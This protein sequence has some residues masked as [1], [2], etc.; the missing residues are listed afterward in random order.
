MILYSIGLA[1]VLMPK[2]QKYLSILDIAHSNIAFLKFGIDTMSLLHALLH[3]NMLVVTSLN[4]NRLTITN[5]FQFS[6]FLIM[7][8][9]FYVIACMCVL[10][11]RSNKMKLP[12]N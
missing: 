5:I 7:Y 10:C 11:T 12:I 2:L 1:L 9:M 4:C 6:Y 3:L 8:N